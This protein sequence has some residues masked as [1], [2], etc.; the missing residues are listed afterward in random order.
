MV[1]S[2]PQA[3]RLVTRLVRSVLLIV[4]AWVAA[5]VSLW[6]LADMVRTETATAASRDVFETVLQSEQKR[7]VQVARD[8]AWWDDAIEKVLLSLDEDWA[9]GNLGGYLQGAFGIDYSV[10]LQG[11]RIALYGARDGARMDVPSA[12]AL[13]QGSLALL[14]AA[15][16]APR[17]PMPVGASGIVL[18]DGRPVLA[19]AVPFTPVSADGPVPPDPDTVLLVARVLDAA[20]LATLGEGFNLPDLH[21]RA[22]DDAQGAAAS[23]LL[24]TLDGVPLAAAVWNP[25]MPGG[26]REGVVLAVMAGLSLT[27]FAVLMIFLRRARRLAHQ[28]LTDD[29]D[30][31]EQAEALAASRV[32]LRHVIGSAPV[33]L[34]VTDSDGRVVLAE[35][36][37][38]EVI[39]PP[40][41]GPPLDRMLE[42]AYG[43]LP[44]FAALFT[45]A[46]RGAAASGTF[47]Y[48]DRA[49]EAACAAVVNEKQAG[50]VV[51]VLTDVTER[52]AAGDVLR[53]AL[54]ELTRSNTELERFA[55]IAS[56]DLQ[57]PVRTMVAYA[58]LTRRRYGGRLDDDGREFLEFIEK[59]ALRMRGLVQGL[60]AYSRLNGSPPAAACDAR[61]AL[62]VALENLADA[63]ADAN[64]ILT[65]G[66]LP[67]VA[68]DSLEL[69]QVFQ[70]LI[71]NALKFRHP[72]RSPRIEVTARPGRSS[73]YWT[74]TVRDDGIGIAPEY[75]QD[76]FVLFKRLHGPG[77]VDGAGVGLAICQRIVERHGGRIWVTSQTGEGSAFHCT[78]P[79]VDEQAIPLTPPAAAVDPHEP[80]IPEKPVRV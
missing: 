40:D 77:S 61:D 64:A 67:L 32:R 21:L 33:A 57:E 22:V 71:G 69:T 24:E 6:L 46:L 8:Y 59:G 28:V 17:S 56:H 76:I 29:A 73:G 14:R 2:P 58:Q 30:R 20:W 26:D 9:D 12:A 38:A 31:M 72:D 49:F 68:M 42:D 53:H 44:G 13:G 80:P 79:A 75:Q 16:T 62:D 50:G 23:R 4:A 78:L 65:V 11:E 70:N 27:M 3:V 35:G 36:R 43:H 18:L 10:V 34:V 41:G 25:A 45:K 48:A 37:E 51:A 60:L 66:T 1:S 74:I 63:I 7:L 52:E 15:R 39:A 55:Y 5:M 19:A 47:W 54:D